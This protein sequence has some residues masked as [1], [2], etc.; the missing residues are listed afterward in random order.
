M[1]TGP[2]P[3]P[4]R[5]NPVRDPAVTRRAND[6]GIHVTVLRSFGATDADG[7]NGEPRIRT[8]LRGGDLTTTVSYQDRVAA[9]GKKLT[10]RG[11][12]LSRAHCFAP[13]GVVDRFAVSDVALVC[14][15]LTDAAVAEELLEGL[16]VG[17]VAVGSVAANR[18]VTTAMAV[19]QQIPAE[20]TLLII[21]DGDTPG[22]TAAVDAGIAVREAHR[23]MAVGVLCT[24]HAPTNTNPTIRHSGTHN[25][26]PLGRLFACIRAF[27]ASPVRS[28]GPPPPHP[29]PHRH[30]DER[31][32]L[33]SWT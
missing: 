8:P 17:A 5:K 4:G 7:R 15:G 24:A 16:D 9:T 3:E 28:P 31:R 22:V 27:A 12:D 30:H 23:G 32:E 1:V 20:A 14:E 21:A 18:M 25:R 11:A 10:E 26:V 19:A 6:L 13:V 33:A 2:T 29:R